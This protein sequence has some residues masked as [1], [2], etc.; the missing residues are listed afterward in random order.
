MGTEEGEAT[1][2]CRAVGKT[3]GEE[4]EGRL[5][6][7]MIPGSVSSC[8]FPGSVSWSWQ[9]RQRERVEK[10]SVGDLANRHEW[11]KERQRRQLQV[12]CCRSRNKTG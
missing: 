6:T 11:E 5:P 1:V 9:L 4:G 10:K 7:Y 3:R 2:C 12:V 8:R